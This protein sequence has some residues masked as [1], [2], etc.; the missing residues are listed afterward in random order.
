MKRYTDYLLFCVLREL[1]ILHKLLFFISWILLAVEK[2]KAR[3]ML[4]NPDPVEADQVD[5]VG[6]ELSRRWLDILGQHST[7]A[8]AVL[9]A[10]WG[11]SAWYSL[12]S[13]A[14]GRPWCC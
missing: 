6:K 9:A 1:G 12:G 14:Q 4:R 5:M 8:Q 3:F 13:L 11:K 10:G 2:L 7:A